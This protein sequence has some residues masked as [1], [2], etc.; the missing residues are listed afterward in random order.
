MESICEW[1]PWFLDEPGSH[2][3]TAVQVSAIPLGKALFE[4]CFLNPLAFWKACFSVL[5]I[6]LITETDPWSM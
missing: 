1:M 2:C 5:F 6:M 3:K 4:Y